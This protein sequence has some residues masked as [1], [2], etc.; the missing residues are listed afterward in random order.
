MEVTRL[1]DILDRYLEEY[2]E[3]K[4]IEVR[5]LMI[6]DLLERGQNEGIDKVL[7]NEKTAK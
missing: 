3:V 7:D 6:S 2:P 5:R 4:G 1:F